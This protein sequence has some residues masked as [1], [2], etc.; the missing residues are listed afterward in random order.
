MVEQQHCEDECFSCTG[1]RHNENSIVCSSN[2]N[3]KLIRKGLCDTFRSVLQV[4]FRIMFQTSAVVVLFLER[5]TAEEHIFFDSGEEGAKIHAK[6][7][8]P[9]FFEFLQF[10]L[11][12]CL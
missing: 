4:S 6:G 7:A 9:K 2:G 5:G 12:I 10:Q 8:K 3:L 1:R 11:Q